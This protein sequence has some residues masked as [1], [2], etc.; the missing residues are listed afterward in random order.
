M[1]AETYILTNE[2]CSELQL[3]SNTQTN[4]INKN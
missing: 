3:E 2:V 4:N 1:D